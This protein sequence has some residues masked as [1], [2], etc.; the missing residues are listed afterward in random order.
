MLIFAVSKGNKVI[1]IKQQYYDKR[2]IY[3]ENS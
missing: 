1:T 2:F 3:S